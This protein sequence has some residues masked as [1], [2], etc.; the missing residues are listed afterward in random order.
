MSKP[1]LSFEHDLWDLGFQ[2]VAGIDEAGRGAWA[3]PVFAAAV[4]LPKRDDLLATLHGAR[5]SKQMTSPEREHWAGEIR[6]T[7]LAWAVGFASAKEID[8][9]GILPATRQAMLRAL[10]SLNR[11]PHYLLIDYIAWKNCPLPH[12]FLIKGDDKSLS[13]A[14][15]SILA[16]TA[17]DK[18]M[19]ELNRQYEGYGFAEHK[20]Y[21]TALHQESIQRLG[22]SDVH[23]KSYRLN[24]KDSR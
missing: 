4:I 20:G 23:R 8:E 19:Q 16:K 17:R 18:H 22:V 5:D 6:L 2:Q 24:K 7:A 14:C 10:A 13:I 21:G 3:G 1:D 15:A 11:M 12:Q 9:I